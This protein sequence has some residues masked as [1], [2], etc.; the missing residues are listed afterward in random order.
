MH[1]SSYLEAFLSVYGWMMYNTLYDLLGMTWLIF[2]PFMK[3]G[4][5]TFIDTVAD[6]GN[7]YAQFKKGLITFLL[8]VAALV[9]AL[10]PLD[11]VT[12]K[13]TTVNGVCIG[14]KVGDNQALKENYRFDVNESG[15]I[16][17]LPS[18]VMRIA[19]GTNNVIY[20]S[21]PCVTDV[22]RFATAM[23]MSEV[24]DKNLVGEMQ[25]F[26]QECGI[27]ARN[28][29]NELMYKAPKTYKNLL[30][31]FKEKDN[32]V[33]DKETNYFNS[34]LYKTMMN[35][36]MNN[37]SGTIDDEEKQI[38][39]ELMQS[40]TAQGDPIYSGS[41]VTDVKSDN[42]D[43][44]QKQQA[45]NK[46]PVSCL[47][48]W[49]TKLLPALKE[50]TSKDL[51]FRVATG[52]DKLAKD[53]VAEYTSET[54]WA[55]ILTG[56]N[57]GVMESACIEATE[58]EYGE[59]L[60]DDLVYYA[61]REGNQ[62]SLMHREDREHA[63][64]FSVLGIVGALLSTFLGGNT[65][66][67]SSIAN[68]A[69]GF[70]T[71]MFFYRV[72]M[73]MLQPML[74][75]GIFCFWGF[76]LVL[77]D[78]RWQTIFKGLVMI[79]II[80]LMPGLWAITQHLDN[81]LWGA[82][83]PDVIK[84]GSAVKQQSASYVERILLDAAGTVFNIIFPMLLMYIVAEAGGG[85]PGGVIAGAERQANN[86]GGVASG[87]SSSTIS[88]AGR[89]VDSR[90]NQARQWRDNRNKILNANKGLPPGGSRF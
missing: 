6:S 53:C 41:S 3:L 49:D 54:A 13:G 44:S 48:W 51:A 1:V 35:P 74:L 62:G 84:L 4:I 70:Y 18:L 9:L 76:Y 50:A 89:G 33:D 75:M 32:Y 22:N 69:V 66:V 60:K 5:T 40:G 25:R 16:P 68:S 14:I 88:G 17:L 31:Q 73:Q 46:G 29:M 77:S 90:I 83:Y 20:Q 72:M 26:N 7:S 86:V 39:E 67:L 19:A 64:T 47:D 11:K 71:Q 59:E 42:P 65:S 78:Y 36:D 55:T 45:E 15:K 81:A 38:V 37:I 58:K 80:T 21:I 8:M 63:K 82:L 30:D 79:F 57:W 2:L 27:P 85:S 12:V 24:T 28:R 23:Q 87:M 52:K 34:S 43:N 61:L 56:K 10:V